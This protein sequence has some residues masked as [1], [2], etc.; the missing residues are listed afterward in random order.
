MNTLIITGA[1]SAAFV[2][3][4]LATLHKDNIGQ[5]LNIIMTRS[6]HSFVTPEALSVFSK[7]KVSEDSFG[8]I[9][10]QAISL[11]SEKVFVYPATFNFVNKVSSGITDT[12]SLMIAQLAL[13]K[14]HLY[15]SLPEGL[16]D[17][18]T[19]IRNRSFLQSAGVTFIEAE[20]G[21]ALSSKKVSEGGCP[22]P[23]KLWYDLKSQAK[24][25]NL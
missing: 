9:D 6:A 4:V 8:E 7:T 15:V 13:D 22:A 23:N 18:A 10:H 16:N 3:G 2:P 14:L 5:N 25:G 21:L 1:P 11:K 24:K 12:L 20:V 17:N 19:Y